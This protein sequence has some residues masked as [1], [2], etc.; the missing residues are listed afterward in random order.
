MRVWSL[1]V[2]VT[3]CGYMGSH[4]VAQAPAA[5]GNNAA[6]ASASPGRPIGVVDI[7]HILQNHPTMK[8]E[9][10]AIKA[11]MEAADKEMAEK[12]DA[13]VAQM[14]QLKEKFA[15]GTPEYDRAEKS[16]AE[17]DTTFRLEL[18]K[19]RKEFETMQANVLYRVYGEI[20]GLLAFLSERTGTQLVIRVHREKMDPKKPETI[21][22]VMSQ[23]VLYFNPSIDLTNWVLEAMTERAKQTAARAGTAPNLK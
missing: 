5:G 3:I 6:A 23:D 16:I 10:E 8:N 17:Q 19:K 2:A 1:V 21:Q 7:G 15:E 20:N 13:I 12:R 4:A 22:T 9:M 14:E 18:V 11:Q